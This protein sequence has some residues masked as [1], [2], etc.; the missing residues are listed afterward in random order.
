MPRYYRSSPAFWDEHRHWSDRQRLLAKYLETCKHR[1][2]EGF[3]SLPREYVAAD[4]GWSPAVVKSTLK[5]LVAADF[6]AYDEASSVVLLVGVLAIQSP[7]T[8]LQMTGAL[9]A[10]DAVPPNALWDRFLIECELHCP[11]LANEIRMRFGL[12]ANG[13]GNAFGSDSDIARTHCSFSSSSSTTE[14]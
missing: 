11:S 14:G 12:L 5:S 2:L 3:Y 10:L 7:S 4:L 1:N 9:N 6:C 13:I 8:A